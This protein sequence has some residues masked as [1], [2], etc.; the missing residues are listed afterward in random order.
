MTLRVG[1]SSAVLSNHDRAKYIDGIG[2]YTAT[3]IRHLKALQ[4]DVVPVTYTPYSQKHRALNPV[5]ANGCAFPYP[6][7]IEVMGSFL[8]DH[9]NRRVEK[10]LSLYHSTDYACPR[11]KNIPVVATLHDAILLKNIPRF[12]NPKHTFNR[13]IMKKRAVHNASHY[14]AITHAMVPELVNYWRVKPEQIDVVPNGIDP[15][16]W[17]RVTVE[18]K[19]ALRN[20]WKLDKPFI[21]F[22]SSLRSRKNLLRLMMAY[23]ALPLSLRNNVQLVVVGKNPG[24]AGTEAMQTVLTDLVAKG[25]AKWLQYVSQKDLRTLYQSASLFVFPSLAEGFGLPIVE[26]FA[27]QLPVITSNRSAMAEVAGDAAYLV[28]PEDTDE[29][30]HAMQLLLLDESL[31]NTYANKGAHRSYEYTAEKQALRTFEVYKKIL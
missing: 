17:E 20:Q 27:S 15:W 24:Y 29:L 2:V 6:E 10:Q 9:F 28:D 3:L 25:E 16:W 30:S 12:E 5:L 22:V 4:C 14:I 21:L 13:Y 7:Y 11:F 19:H 8:S 23:K 18:E 31:A 26:A 1:I